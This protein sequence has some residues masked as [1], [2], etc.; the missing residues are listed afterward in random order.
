MAKQ[1]QVFISVFQINFALC[2]VPCALR[3]FEHGQLFYRW[4]QIMPAIIFWEMFDCKTLPF[5]PL[6]TP[7]PE[8][9][10]I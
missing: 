4:H 10:T 2:F 7:H 8:T 3:A 6:A 9:I 5:L 1:L